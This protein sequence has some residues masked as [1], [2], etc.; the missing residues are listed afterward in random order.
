MLDRQF[1][2]TQFK[3][4]DHDCQLHTLFAERIV[5]IGPNWTTWFLEWFDPIKT[6]S[7]HLSTDASDD[8][9]DCKTVGSFEMFYKYTNSKK[10][11]WGSVNPGL[12][13]L[14]F[15]QLFLIEAKNVLGKY[16]N[17]K[18]ETVTLPS[19]T[20][21]LSQNISTLFPFALPTTSTKNR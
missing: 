9:S 13:Q 17:V 4:Y 16:A 6:T 21:S 14:H 2:W 12:Y 7:I 19:E 15:K 1:L 3:S 18:K 10:E 5:R 8:G 20:V 11:G